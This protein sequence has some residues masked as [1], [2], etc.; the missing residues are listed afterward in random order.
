MTLIVCW[1]SGDK[2]TIVADS[3]ISGDGVAVTDSGAKL[4]LIPVVVTPFDDDGQLP[5]LQTTYGFAFAGSTLIANNTHA[6]AS[7]CTQSLTCPRETHLPDVRAIAGLYASV[8]AHCYGDVNSRR[9]GQIAEIQ[10]LVFGYCPRLSEPAVFC[11]RTVVEE[12]SFRVVVEAVDIIEPHA[13]CIGSGAMMMNRLSELRARSGRPRHHLENF[14]TVL[15][16]GGN[17][18]VGG[19]PQMAE[20]GPDGTVLRIIATPR[21]GNPDDVRH[22]VLGFDVTDIAPID[23]LSIGHEVVGIRMEETWGRIALRSYGVDPDAGPVS[24]ELQNTASIEMMIGFMA[25]PGSGGQIGT[26][27]DEITIL[28]PPVE[29]GEMCFGAVCA[30]CGGTAPIARDRSRVGSAVNLTGRGVVNVA[31]A[32]CGEFTSIRPTDVRPMRFSRN[33]SGSD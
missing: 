14:M 21:D 10:G 6:I 15:E 26:I 2:I 7:N 9:V 31:C 19:Y 8:L 1:R 11:L 3:R 32:S 24:R 29:E 12:T 25:D 20:A 4:F 5:R 30:R 28:T 27:N 18:G 13:I 17:V 23:G 33:V 22:R 16:H